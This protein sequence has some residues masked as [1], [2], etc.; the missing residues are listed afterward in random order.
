MKL[1]RLSAVI[2][3]ITVIFLIGFLALQFQSYKNFMGQYA[4]QNQQDTNFDYHIIHI[5]FHQ[6]SRVRLINDEFTSLNG[7]DMASF[8]TLISNSHV[9]QIRPAFTK[10]DS[11]A[12]SAAD[13]DHL[14][15][16]YLI[17]LKPGTSVDYAKQLIAQLNQHASVDMAYPDTIGHA[18]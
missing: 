7:E 18:N 2:I 1:P 10:A 12:T 15:S 13:L 11:Y 3:L 4:S 14:L 16:F 6:T 9:A 17:V 5:Q 8:N